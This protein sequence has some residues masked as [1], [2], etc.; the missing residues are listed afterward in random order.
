LNVEA[1]S[2]NGLTAIN[3]TSFTIVGSPITRL[4]NYNTSYVVSAASL[5]K[6]DFKV[7]YPECA[8]YQGL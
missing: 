1:L 8:A 2:N 3:T 7:L 6:I 5:L 4:A